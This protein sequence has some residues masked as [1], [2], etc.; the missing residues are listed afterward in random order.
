MSAS[1]PPPEEPA[2]LA[3]PRPPARRRRSLP[4]RRRRLLFLPAPSADGVVA[5]GGAPDA[6]SLEA[7]YR[8]GVFPWPHDG[9]PLLWFCPDPRFVLRPASARLPRSLCKR[10]RRGTYEVRADTAFAEVIARCAA[11]ERPEQDGTWITREMIAGYRALHARGLAHSIE[12]WRE[13]RL[14]G[15]LYGVSLGA[16]FFG[17]SMF[18]DAPDAS[19]VCLG[20]LLANLAHWKFPLLD[21]QSHTDHLAT[22]GA[23]EWPRA[24]FLDVL[25]AALAAPTRAGRWKLD[26]GPAAAADLFAGRDGA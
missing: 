22:F 16:V 3:E 10:M 2:D 6:D 13:G 23:V 25:A 12:A 8:R 9:Y 7:A 21:C 24:L 11:K 5:I 26:L 1:T 4:P 20:T 18:A 19:K 14:A 15:G 17:E